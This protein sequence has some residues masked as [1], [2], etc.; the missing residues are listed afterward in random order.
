VKDLPRLTL[1]LGGA[2]SGKSRYA[3]GL[4]TAAGGGTYL[5]TAQALDDEMRARIAEHRARRAYAWTTL[6]E[7]LDL[8]GA[9]TRAD[10]A[11]PVLIDCLTLWLSN[12]MLAGRDI[13]AAGDAV[14]AALNTRTAPVIA[15]SN[16][17]GLGIVPDNALARAFRDAQGTLN[18]R[19]AL[20]A[21]R[22]I[23]MVAG[24]PSV[25]KGDEKD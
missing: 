1:V 7:P 10:A 5:A 13:D 17:V 8:A 21:D 6:E 19:I 22:V 16:E 23:L 15:V 2:R 24:L 9:L 3:E 20:L 14:I 12:L 11:R 18:Q 4:I 25:V